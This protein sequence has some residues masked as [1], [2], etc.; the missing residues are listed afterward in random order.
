MNLKIKFFL[1][2]TILFLQN[3][4]I[5]SS[6]IKNKPPI[7]RRYVTA[8]S[9]KVRSEPNLKSKTVGCLKVF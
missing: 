7:S 4:I 9:L 6:D 2:I 3:T 5:D 8:N 1:F